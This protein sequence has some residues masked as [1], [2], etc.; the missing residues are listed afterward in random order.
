MAH[1]R[2]LSIFVAISTL[3]GLM[4]PALR[5]DATKCESPTQNYAYIYKF[6]VFVDGDEVAQEDPVALAWNTQGYLL[7]DQREAAGILTQSWRITHIP[8]DEDTINASGPVEGN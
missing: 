5:A 6:M 3:T 7:V 8:N 1:R 4:L 2:T